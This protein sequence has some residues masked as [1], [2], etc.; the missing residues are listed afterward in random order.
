LVARLTVL[1]RRAESMRSL[2]SGP[3][4]QPIKSTV[5]AIHSLRGGTGCS[6]M[7]VNMAIGLKK[8]WGSSVIV[9][10]LV[11]TAG[12]VA[13]MLNATLR[14]TWSDLAKVKPEE[15]DWETLKSIIG[16]HE[17]GVHYIAAPT[18]PSEAEL[19]T[20]EIFERAFTML[21]EHFEYIVVDLPHDF[22]GM[23]IQ[24][25]DAADTIVLMV[26]P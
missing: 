9:I 25:L 21:K 23:T 19:F 7:A 26:A 5:I 8:L 6:S 15:M 11:L 22:S 14:R 13:L 16:E 20:P 12:Q 1:L 4:V 17:C 10:D 18:F 24:A 2:P 3:A